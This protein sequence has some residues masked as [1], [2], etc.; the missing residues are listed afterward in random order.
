MRGADVNLKDRYRWTPLTAS[1][2]GRLA[3]VCLLCDARGIDL[4]APSN[5]E[6]DQSFI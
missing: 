4:S 3:I 1:D 2:L 6:S 5:G